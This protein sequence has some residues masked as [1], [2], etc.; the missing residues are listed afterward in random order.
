MKKIAYGFGSI[1]IIVL[2]LIA[3]SVRPDIPVEQL[4]PKYANEHSKFVTIDGLTVHYR[5]EG[6]G[7]PVVL[8]HG[9]PSS[10]HTWDALAR[11]LSSHYRVIRMDL[12]GYGLTGPNPAHDYST[13]SYLDFLDAFLK[14]VH[15][16]DCYLIG[17]SFGGRIAAEFAYKKKARVKKLVLI[18]S[19]GYPQNE[20]AMPAVKMA[21]SPLL[22]P[23]VRYATPRFFIGMNVRE[24]Y[25]TK[26]VPEETIDRYYD[27]LRREGNRETFIAMCNRKP[28]DISSHVKTIQA[29]ALI[30][31]GDRDTSI[32]VE[33]AERFHRDSA[34]SRMVIYTG[35][36][37]VPHEVM[38]E[39]TASDILAFLR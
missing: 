18:A 4:K 30:I 16:D 28:D 11:N 34:K 15:V 19:S 7:F 36:G 39:R 21:R 37:H 33:Y 35:A 24:A 1:I 6:A 25:G 3:S 14:A 29:S 5:D 17:H 12:P 13:R 2:L 31:W 32:P 20:D 8:L 9:S 23:L 26:D 22:R 10:L 38:P 27:L